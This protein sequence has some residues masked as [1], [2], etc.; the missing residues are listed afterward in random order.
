MGPNTLFDLSK[1]PAPVPF[2]LREPHTSECLPQ[3]LPSPFLMPRTV[4]GYRRHPG[5]SLS[6]E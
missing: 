3:G 2:F 5:S 4:R 6:L 1:D